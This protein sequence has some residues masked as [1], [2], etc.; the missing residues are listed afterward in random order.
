MNRAAFRTLKETSPPIPNKAVPT[1]PSFVLIFHHSIIIIKLFTECDY[2]EYQHFECSFPLTCFVYYYGVTHFKAFAPF[3]QPAFEVKVAPPSV[4]T[5]SPLRDQ[6]TAETSLKRKLSSG[7]TR[8][9][10]TCAEVQEARA[11]M[12]LSSEREDNTWR[13]LAAREETADRSNS[14]RT[15]R[16]TLCS[17]FAARRTTARRMARTAL[18]NMPTD[19]PDKTSSSKVQQCSSYSFVYEEL[20]L[21]LWWL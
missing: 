4:Q 1:I 12:P 16:L 11:R 8:P 14:S 3:T 17:G 21:T 2:F 6:T 5:P 10:Y 13:P 18:L 9:L 19:L 20:E 7:S 15:P